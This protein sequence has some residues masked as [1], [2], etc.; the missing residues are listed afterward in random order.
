LQ[1]KSDASYWHCTKDVLHDYIFPI[2]VLTS[3]QMIT[4]NR[5]IYKHMFTYCKWNLTHE[6]TIAQ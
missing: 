2:V 1:T 5:I 3:N 4:Y 6:T